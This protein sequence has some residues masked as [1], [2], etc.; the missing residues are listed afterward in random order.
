M[1]YTF[2]QQEFIID[3]IPLSINIDSDEMFVE[4][5]GIVNNRSPQ[6]WFG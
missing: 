6:V 2:L 3:T 1:E 5:R 4:S